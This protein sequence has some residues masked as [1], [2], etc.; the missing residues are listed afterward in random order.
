M[1]VSGARGAVS[2]KALR[3]R[4][5]FSLDM[6]RAKGF[7]DLQ[8]EGSGVRSKVPVL[9]KMGYEVESGTGWVGSPGAHVGKGQSG[10]RV[11]TRA[12]IRA[13]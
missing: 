2:W 7:S 9:E 1:P 11:K 8:V 10:P 13:V 4:K 12:R 3:A 6:C 5:G